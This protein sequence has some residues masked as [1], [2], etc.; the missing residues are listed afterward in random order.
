M[1]RTESQMF[2]N[3][4]WLSPLRL[5]FLLVAAH[6]ATG[7]AALAQSYLNGNTNSSMVQ[8]GTNSTMVQ[9]GTNGT[10]V[11]GG[12]NSSLVRGG[13][14]TE[15]QDVNILFLID[16]SYSMKEKFGGSDRK[17][18]GAKQVIERAI[19]MIPASINVG[20]RVFGQSFSGAPEIDCRQTYMLV[21]MAQHNRGSLITAVRTIQPSG[22]TPLEY[23]LRRCVEEDF[24][25]CQGKKTIILIS[26]GQDTC[27][28]DPCA[29][30]TQL[31]RYGISIRCDVV[32]LE[33]KKNH[34]AQ[35]ELNC[36]AQASGGKYYDA[37]NID[38]LIQS[39]VHSV[40][41]A[42]SGKVILKPKAPPDQPAGSPASGGGAGGAGNV[43]S[44]GI[45]GIPG[46]SANSGNP[47]NS[48]NSAGSGGSVGAGSGA[49][50]G[51]GSKAPSAVP[52]LPA[53]ASPSPSPSPA[54]SSTA[55]SSSKNSH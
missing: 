51:S 11:Q 23:A 46:R 53:S 16:A 45:T 52:E 44:P 17:M 28:G 5:S 6:L 41:R 38:D 35:D 15:S 8:G 40:N 20:V 29:Y 18:S 24:S 48:A 21:P 12:T 49:G 22:L 26:D 33:L 13:V 54:S 42:I 2:P 34:K 47:A 7:S 25:R 14:D 10:M 32:G 55:P 9:G 27:G 43:V 36:L 4:E 39:V 31:A 50:G 30:M 19:S 3:R 37:N 1:N